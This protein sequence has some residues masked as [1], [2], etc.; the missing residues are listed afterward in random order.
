L[1][2]LPGRD[3][4]HFQKLP[5]FPCKSIQPNLKYLLLPDLHNSC[6]TGLELSLHNTPQ[7][8]GRNI[9]LVS[10]NPL[11]RILPDGE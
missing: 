4:R 11:D 3:A 10:K 8:R 7:D 9:P 5:P 6:E 2:P 1:P